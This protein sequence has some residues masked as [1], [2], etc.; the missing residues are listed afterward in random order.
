MFNVQK[1]LQIFY[2]N[3]FNNFASIFNDSDKFFSRN[4]IYFTLV[5]NKITFQDYYHGKIF[6]IFVVIQTGPWVL[7]RNCQQIAQRYRNVLRNFSSK[8]F[9]QL[10]R[11]PMIVIHGYSSIFSINTPS[12]VFKNR[13]IVLHGYSCIF[14]T[15]TSRNA[16][17]RTSTGSAVGILQKFILNSEIPQESLHFFLTI[18]EVS[19]YSLRIPKCVSPDLFPYMA[20]IVLTLNHIFF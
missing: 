2:W 10:Y 16:Y 17:S 9:Q 4:I 11:S 5:L 13:N 7:C 14:L 18:P 1:L 6:K 12:N 19:L 3:F 15:I 8:Y 20:S